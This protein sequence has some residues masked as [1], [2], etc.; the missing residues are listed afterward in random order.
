[1]NQYAVFGHPVAHSRSPW[2]HARF[3]AQFGFE[4]SYQAID[5]PP[6]TF[7]QIL[8]DFGE[9]GG[10]GANVTLPLKEQA[11]TLCDELSEA[12]QRARAVNT[13]IRLPGLRWRG[14]NTDGIGLVADFQRLGIE[15]VGR[16]IVILG[17][18][19]ATRGILGPLLAQGPREIVIANRT[20]ERALQLALESGALGTVQAWALDE[21][22]AL[23]AADVLVNATSA[24]RGE[25]MALAF[26]LVDAGTIAYDLSYGATAQPFLAQ[27][28]QAGTAEVHDGLGM[29]V[30]QAAESFRHWR[31]VRPQTAPV[32]AELRTLVGH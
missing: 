12:A 25:G 17:A 14:D 31:G 4:Q 28:R 20:P 16:R 11:A 30:E 6:E 29:L 27:A 1:M 26:G 9:A 8:W 15:L 22:Q 2:I 18:G 10:L 5:V 21:L 19:G 32:L 3:A 13:L 7:E 24:W 23:E